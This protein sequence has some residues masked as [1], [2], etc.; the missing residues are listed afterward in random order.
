MVPCIQSV[1][2]VIS[3][4]PAEVGLVKVNVWDAPESVKVKLFAVV[5]V[6]V[7]STKSGDIGFT[8]T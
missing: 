2:A 1:E 6:I 8:N 5:A 7:G 3:T 4:N